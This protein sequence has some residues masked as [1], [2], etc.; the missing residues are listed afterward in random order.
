MALA[1]YFHRSAVALAQVLSGFDEDAIRSK[2]EEK[3]VGIA[4][5]SDSVT[6]PE[7]RATVE[8]AVRL[9]AR[10]YPRL[11][12]VG[13]D[14]D[15]LEHARSL[16]RLINPSIDISDGD[17]DILVAVGSTEMTAP[18]MI[19]VGS[20]G[21]DAHV[22]TAGPKELGETNNPFGAGAAACF[23]AANVFRAVFHGEHAQFDEELTLSTLDM[24][25]DATSDNVAIDDVDLGPSNVLIGVGAIGNAAV[26]A[27]GRSPLKGTVHLV[28]N[29]TLE[30]SN[31]QRYVLPVRDNENRAKVE[32]AAAAFHGGLVPIAHPLD[33]A[34]FA[35]TEGYQW[36]RVIVALDSARHRRAVQASLPR[37]IANAWTQP[38]DLGV[39]THS[40]TEGA[41]LSCLYLPAGELPNED[42]L[43]ATALGIAR[44]E[45]ELQI[46]NLLHAGASPPREMLEEIAGKLEVPLD[47][48]LPFEE[49]PLRE[50]YV[51]GICGGV[52][53]PLSRI[54]TPTQ[55]VHI[56]IAHQSALAGVLLAGRLVAHA[57]QRVPTGAQVS[58]IN[59]LEPLP[60]LMGSLTQPIAKDPR[61][62]CIC[63]DRVYAD[64]YALKYSTEN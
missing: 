64:A 48:L 60:Q 15:F 52:V 7:G 61:G 6:K 44:P 50:L 46:R 41:C 34:T 18:L 31:M 32:L 26:W 24:T 62:L 56:P 23:G 12:L 1:D 35:A 37:W 3:T 21:W 16:A 22:S 2:L 29:Q 63:Q 14:I 25:T 4:F 43:I 54:G 58:R 47:A 5:S 42:K 55:D 45:R 53:L 9:L 27:L 51:V 11:V 17:A 49:R 8:L 39:S 40:W 57:I 28:D 38:G 13:G 36:Q 19:F 30:L 20:N 59:V 10:L 33:W